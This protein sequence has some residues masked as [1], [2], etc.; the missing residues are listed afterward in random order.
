MYSC[1]TYRIEKFEKRMC[2]DPIDLNHI[3][4]NYMNFL[5][6]VDLDQHLN[7][8]AIFTD[9]IN[10]YI[11]NK[12]FPEIEK[13]Y[14]NSGLILCFGEKEKFYKL[15]KRTAF[16]A[17]PEQLNGNLICH[18]VV[19]VQVFNPIVGTLLLVE[20]TQKLSI[21]LNSH[22]IPM[23]SRDVLKTSVDQGYSAYEDSRSE[24]HLCHTNSGLQFPVCE[25]KAFFSQVLKQFKDAP[26]EC[27]FN[28]GIPQNYG[29][30]AECNEGDIIVCEV[31]GMENDLCKQRFRIV[32]GYK[33][34]F[35]KK[36]E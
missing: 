13:L 24:S 27:R 33:G 29:I 21:G 5:S 28:I 12:S 20:I 14:I 7:H 8:E 32:A 2:L 23:T 4:K 35:C 10:D 34:M 26:I 31:L 17:I 36:K 30:S 3:Y 18:S 6:S 25:E 22:V 16:S 11:F 1:I 19:P 15:L 9:I